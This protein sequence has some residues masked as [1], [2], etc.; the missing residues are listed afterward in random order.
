MLKY[1]HD[2]LIC[3]NGRRGCGAERG[4]AGRCQANAFSGLTRSASCRGRSAT[5]KIK[6]LTIHDQEDEDNYYGRLRRLRQLL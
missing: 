3:I 4:G 5:L 1:I 2:D 6:M